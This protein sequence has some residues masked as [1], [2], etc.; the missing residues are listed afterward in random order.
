MVGEI[1]RLDMSLLPS[2]EEKKNRPLEKQSRGRLGRANDL[3]V[4]STPLRKR[5]PF[6]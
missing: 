2:A 6:S 1:V 5:M 4:T 3:H